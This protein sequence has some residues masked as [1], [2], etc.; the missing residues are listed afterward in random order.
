MQIEELPLLSVFT[1]LREKHRLS[2]GISEYVEVVRCLKDGV[3]VNSKEDLETLCYFVWATSDEERLLIKERLSLMW[4]QVKAARTEVD[5]SGADNSNA[6]VDIDTTVELEASDNNSSER[7]NEQAI[8]DPQEEFKSNLEGDQAESSE[9]SQPSIDAVIDDLEPVDIAKAYRRRER[10]RKQAR[11]SIRAEYFPVTKRQMSQNWRSLRR[12]VRQGIETELDVFSTVQRIGKQGIIGQP[13]LRAPRVNQA[14]VMLL[15]D[16]NGSMM[17]F[18]SLSRQLVETAI[19]G[20]RFKSVEVFYFHNC[21]DQYLFKHFSL[22]DPILLEDVLANADEEVS[23]LI[24]S[25]AG[26]ARGTYS[27]ERIDAIENWIG[28]IKQSI[29]HLAWV[30]P[31]PMTSWVGSSAERVAQSVPMF[32]MS[33]LGMGL[34]IDVL[35]GRYFAA[36]KGYSWLR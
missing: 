14:Q 34:A 20:A 21:P 24:V 13:V 33:R 26:A 2:L 29:Q 12:Y 35:R 31:M 30:N 32:E 3:G 18:H 15:I 23:T 1:D 16:Q 22:S 19:K 25:D 27:P 7:L 10:T 4:A 36:K 11:F 9:I 5:L 17:P 6:E 28:S 8:E